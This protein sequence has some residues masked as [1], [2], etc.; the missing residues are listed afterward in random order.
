[1]KRKR[2]SPE[3]IVTKLREAD[4]M[5]AGGAGNLAVNPGWIVDYPTETTVEVS[6]CTSECILT[7]NGDVV[8][9]PDIQTLSVGNHL[10]NVSSQGNENYTAFSSAGILRVL[11]V[12]APALEAISPL[13]VTYSISSIV[14]NV[15][16]NENGSWCGFSLDGIDNV[17]MSQY[18]LTYFTYSE[19]G[20]TEGSHTA[21]FSCNDSAGNFNY[22]SVTFGVDTLAPSV[23][24]SYPLNSS[25]G[26]NVSEL[27]YSFTESNPD[28]CWYSIDE[29]ATNSSAESC[30]TSFAG[31][32]SSDGS[33]TWIVYINDTLGR[34]NSTSVTFSRDTAYPTISFTSNTESTGSVL[35]NNSLYAEV[36]LGK[37]ENIANVSYNLFNAAGILVNSTTLDGAT[38]NF[39]WTEL[40]SGAY[41]Y[42]V[43]VTDVFGNTNK[44]ETR[45][46]E[47]TSSCLEQCPE[48]FDCNIIS[49]CTLYSGL[50]SDD[51]CNFGSFRLSATIYTLTNG[52]GDANNLDLNLTNNT[53]LTKS[54]IIFSGKNG[55]RGGNAGVV[56]ISVVNLFNTKII[57]FIGNGGN[58]SDAQYSGGNGGILQLNYRGLISNFSGFGNYRP[59][60]DAGV[61]LN[62]SSGS[63]GRVIYNK[64]M[65]CDRAAGVFRDVDVNGDGLVALSDATGIQLRYN[66]M[67]GDISFDENYDVDCSNKINVIEIVRE[68]Y[69]YHTR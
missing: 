28:K 9:S 58:S 16:L 57:R 39:T 20:L 2:H 23:S 38:T 50:C 54:A 27:N 3:Q 21:V 40:T 14:F 37:T 17:S 12:Q 36:E 52:S 30:G 25:Y 56:N 35:M 4:A 7:R 43:S 46:I 6:G 64:Q 48:G 59:V 53:F 29:G 62:G 15:S 51:V 5:L 66:N 55:I 26:V 18:N 10:Y 24:I 34:E 8:S 47:L 32:S 41:K 11:D 31:I 22:S 42:N 69:E 63:V 68:G 19:S 1:M 67:S 65:N 13:N 44:T 61:A 49:N 60:L 45:T 33:N